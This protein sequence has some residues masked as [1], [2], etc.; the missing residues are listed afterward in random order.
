VIFQQARRDQDWADQPGQ[1]DRIWI[2]EGSNNNI[3]DYAIIKNAYVGLQTEV[4]GNT[5]G[6]PGRL[7][8]TNTRIQNM[9]LWGLYSL[10]YNIYG[11][12]NSISNCQEYCL[13]ILLGGNYNFI[14]CTFANYWN[15]DKARD[16]PTIFIN[17]HTTSQVL[18]L[19]T[20]VFANC[21]IDGK[22]DNELGFD[23]NTSDNTKL[24]KH[25]FRNCWIKT[26]IDVSDVN[27][28]FN[29]RTGTS[30]QYADPGSYIWQPKNSETQVQ[31]FNNAQA[32]QDATLFSNDLNG[33]LRNKISVTVGAYE[34]S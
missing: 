34:P 17:N 14:H 32:T 1:W 13:N 7:R 5:F 27:H 12:N 25:F 20:C 28:Y 31:G 24:P 33:H 22:L 2:N 6:L 23:L 29:V 3:I 26:N 19:D 11:G 15:G 10:G 4:F 16:K 21:L 8:L 18:P 30:P 9:S